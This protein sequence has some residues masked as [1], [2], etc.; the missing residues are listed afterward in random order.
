MGKLVDEVLAVTEVVSEV[1]VGKL[2]YKNVKKD[3]AL[4]IAATAY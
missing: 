3:S 1:I 2:A 4:G